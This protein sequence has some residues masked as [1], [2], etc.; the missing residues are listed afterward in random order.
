MHYKEAKV[1]ILIE[2]CFSF[3]AVFVHDVTDASEVHRGIGGHGFGFVFLVLVT[4]HNRN[5]TRK[6]LQQLPVTH[7]EPI[8]LKGLL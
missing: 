3:L 6:K 4:H 8:N 2:L 7:L 1:A 5:S